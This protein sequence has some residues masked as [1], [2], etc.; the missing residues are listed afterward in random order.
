MS[1]AERRNRIKKTL[2]EIITRDSSS[3]EADVAR[4]RLQEINSAL[5]EEEEEE[6]NDEE[7]LD[8][9]E[10]STSE[11]NEDLDIHNVL[12]PNNRWERFKKGLNSEGIAYYYT[13]KCLFKKE[14][15]S[16]LKRKKWIKDETI[17]TE[18]EKKIQEIKNE[19]FLIFMLKNIL[20]DIL[21][22]GLG[23][24]NY[25]KL[26]PIHKKCSLL[27]NRSR[28]IE[29]KNKTS[30]C[31]TDD[32]KTI[33]Y[34]CDL[35]KSNISELWIDW[36]KHILLRKDF[37]VLQITLID[38]K[39]MTCDVK[40]TIDGDLRI[41]QKVTV[42]PEEEFHYWN[43]ES[44]TEIKDFMNKRAKVYFEND[45]KTTR[46]KNGVKKNNNDILFDELF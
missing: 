39:N 15:K 3:A 36:K 45:K 29:V 24:R 37:V 14:F 5:N 9:Q 46:T 32:Y 33:V 25:T 2:E 20:E 4:I 11:D 43:L 22:I 16:F 13:R 38:A 28:I 8:S 19:Y 44:L 27:K 12:M 18:V 10:S 35:Q 41:H 40:V 26:T 7:S 17:S 30:F 42:D 6:N 23:H 21:T 34:S 31:F 1:K